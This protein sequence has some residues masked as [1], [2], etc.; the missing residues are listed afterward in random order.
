MWSESPLKMMSVKNLD[1]SNVRA[2]LI[3]PSFDFMSPAV[4]FQKHPGEE[5][6]LMGYARSILLSNFLSFVLLTEVINSLLM[7]AGGSAFNR[8]YVQT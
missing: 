2:R 8:D 7:N 5:L 1:P 3:E 4:S 6:N